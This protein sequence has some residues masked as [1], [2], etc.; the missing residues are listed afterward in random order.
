MYEEKREY[1]RGLCL[2]LQDADPELYEECLSSP[3]GM[4]WDQN[5]VVK[6]V[7]KHDMEKGMVFPQSI[8]PI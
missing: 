5:G 2:Y 6:S 4:W 8:I 3:R 1:F 7:Y